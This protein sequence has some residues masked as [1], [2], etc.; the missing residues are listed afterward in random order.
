MDDLVCRV[1]NS[2][3]HLD[4]LGELHRFQRKSDAGLPFGWSLFSLLRDGAEHLRAQAEMTSMFSVF[5]GQTP[6]DGV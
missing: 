6:F 3:A 1:W 2:L 4:D 5:S